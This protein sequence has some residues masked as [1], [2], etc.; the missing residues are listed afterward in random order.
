MSN[1]K[2]Q[3][4]IPRSYLKNFAVK[5]DDKYFVEAKMLNE[6][7]V[8]ENLLSIVD[9]CVSKNLY[10]VPQAEGE[11]KYAIEKYYANEV[12]GIYPEIYKLLTN[13]EISELTEDQRRKIILTTMS[14]FF[15]TPKFLNMN[16]KYLEAVL[17]HAIEHHMDSSGM[18]KFENTDFK[19]DFHVSTLGE[20][21]EELKLQNKLNFIENHMKD[22]HEFVEYKLQAGLMV[23]EI[24]GDGDLIT[25]DNPVIMKSQKSSNFDVFDPTNIINL[26]IDNKH[27][28]MIA[29][30]SEGAMKDQVF[31]SSHSDIMF[32]LSNNLQ[33]EQNAESWIF[34]KPGTVSSHISDQIKYNELTAENLKHLEDMQTRSKNYVELSALID[35]LGITHQNVIAYMA[36]LLEDPLHCDDPNIREDYEQLKKLGYV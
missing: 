33:V 20:I 19:L 24:T 16:N 15:R 14:L 23:I 26:P 29:P 5:Q 28:L 22:L 27:Y 25:S 3:H 7:G 10:T 4:F 13:T 12:D 21:R 35:E 18:V 8:K 30:N 17:D 9:I 11:E 32:V 6:S 1:P 2:R 31:R 36:A 34:G